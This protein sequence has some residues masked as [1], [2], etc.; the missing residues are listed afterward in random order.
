[1]FKIIKTILKELE[2]EVTKLRDSLLKGVEK[3]SYSQN[4][5]Q[6]GRRHS[7]SYIHSL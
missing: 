5:H 2:N 7:Y 6:I 3:S 1:M 4:P